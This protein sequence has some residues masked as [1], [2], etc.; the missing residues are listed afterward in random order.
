V[1]EEPVE[2]KR[3]KNSKSDIESLDFNR[4]L[5]KL[6][7][8]QR[9]DLARNQGVAPFVIFGDSTLIEMA[10]YYPQ[11][12][13]SLLKIHGV[14]RA[15]SKKYGADFLDVIIEYSQQHDLKERSKSAQPKNRPVKKTLSKKSRPYEV[16][17]MFRDGRSV[18]DIA[19]H[20]DVKD[21][22]V[23]SNLV[24]FVKA[25]ESLP[26]DHLL[27]ISSL[28][29]AEMKQVRKAFD[30]HGHELLRPVFD[31]LDEAIPYDELRIVQLY[32]MVENGE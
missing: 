5:F 6:L 3:T 8:K 28:N 19:S 7:K 26:N 20:F 32:L 9:M 14:G 22:T 24:K 16:G 15:K 11:S 29:K 18:K 17:Q 2:Q 23:I 4:N 30:N 1:I 25:G 21:G 10:Y 13:E 31:E 12:E 27:D